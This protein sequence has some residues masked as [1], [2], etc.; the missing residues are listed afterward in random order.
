MRWDAVVVGSGFGGLACAHLLGQRG[1]RVAVLE[2]AA[3]MGGCTMAYK[4]RGQEL[5]TGLHYIGGLGE[6][7]SLRP[8]FEE[9]NLMH[10]PW[11]QMDE[12]F[13]HITVGGRTYCFAQGFD[14]FVET[15]VKDFPQDREGLQRLAHLLHQTATAAAHD[16]SFQEQTQTSAWQYLC[17]NIQSPLL[18]EIL[19]TP[20]SL[21]GEMNKESLP[22]FTFL[23]VNSGCIE[24]AWRL[25]GSGNL[26][27]ESLVNDIRS[28]G[29]EVFPRHRVI[30]LT[31]EEG[32]IT[33]AVCEGGMVF[34][35][36][37]FISDAHP[38]LTMDMVTGKTGIY[39]R[40]LRNLANTEGT[41][42]ATVVLRPEALPYFN[43]NHYLLNEADGRRMLI[44]ARIPEDGSDYTRVLDLLTPM[45]ITDIEPGNDY[46]QRKTVLANDLIHW[47]ESVLPGL[48]DA[49]EQ[50]YISTPH[51]Y[52][53]YTSTP[54]G[55]SFGIRKDWRSP[56]TTFL[57]PR[58]PI[59]NLWL[60]G[61]SLMV[62]GMQGVAMAAKDTATQALS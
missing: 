25:A 13:E 22:L 1:L 11:K 24:S 4:R 33:R 51:T 43:H 7:Q 19:C 53:R 62:H 42:T 35:A 29:G 38:A 46:N 20:I 30:E 21:K 60:T 3:L 40:R 56:L 2:Q 41:L 48:S 36:D 58:T 27:V 55:S 32:R 10:L 28:F 52:Q 16:E 12:C 6:G 37:L 47:A 54:N 49:I 31:Q 17:D 50:C 5:D 9:L 18:R 57:S 23:H 34:E 8:L 39:G 61:Q 15:L 44:S 26:I 45:S 14:Q 59:A